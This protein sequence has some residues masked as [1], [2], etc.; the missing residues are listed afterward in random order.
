MPGFGWSAAIWKSAWVG[1]FTIFVEATSPR[2]PSS[3]AN[4]LRTLADLFIYLFYVVLFAYLAKA[5]LLKRFKELAALRAHH[6]DFHNDI[7]SVVVC[8]TAGRPRLLLLLLVE[9][10]SGIERKEEIQEVTASLA[11]AKG[12]SASRASGHLYS[13]ELFLG[14]CVFFFFFFSHHFL[15]TFGERFGLYAR[16]RGGGF[17]KRCLTFLKKMRLFFSRTRDCSR[18]SFT[19]QEFVCEILITVSSHYLRIGN[20]RLSTHNHSATYILHL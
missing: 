12:I 4:F 17:I 6:R 14:G 16:L 7:S 18:G 15:T 3:C 20:S 19:P 13:W 8:W 5:L 9:K 10:K 1:C 2:F 11:A